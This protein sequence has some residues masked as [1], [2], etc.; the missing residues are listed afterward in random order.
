M[1][2][3]VLVLW[4]FTAGAGFST[5]LSS[6]LGR[7]RPAAEVPLPSDRAPAT[8]AAPATATAAAPGTAAAFA[9]TAAPGALTPEE[10]KQAR[11]ERFDP[12]SLVAARQAPVVPGA[13]AL[14]EFAHPAFG[15]IGLAFW[16]GFSLV[17]NRLLGWIAFGLV[18]VTAC[19][20][21]AWFTAN[22]RAA[23]RH[24]PDSGEPA[25]S[26]RPRMVAVHGGAAALTFILA[27]LTIV[28]LHP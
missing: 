11:R 14:L 21:L 16:L 3:L 2:V 7:S 25:P 9:A 13:R 23:R 5:L 20:G 1:A 28:I 18:A 22:L 12:A 26:F 24:D 27:A 8:A 6:N 17:H 4:L 19:A 15:I 10:L